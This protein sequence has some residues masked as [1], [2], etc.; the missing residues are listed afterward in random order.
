MLTA[1]RFFV[2]PGHLWAVSAV[3]GSLLRRR[4]SVSVVLDVQRFCNLLKF[5]SVGFSYFVEE[6]GGRS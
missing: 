3:G 2:N 5:G 4:S 1:R 6:C